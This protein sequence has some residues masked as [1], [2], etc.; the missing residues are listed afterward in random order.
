MMIEERKVQ[1]LL[2]GN[3][4]VVMKEES[5]DEADLKFE[6]Y[7]HYLELERRN[8]RWCTEEEIRVD[9][10]EIKKQLADY[11]IKLQKKRKRARRIFTKQ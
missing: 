4:D 1:N 5:K 7:V 6:Y 10:S 3:Q 11:E 2:D 9:E 8:D